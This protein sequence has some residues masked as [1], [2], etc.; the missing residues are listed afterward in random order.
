M[1]EFKSTDSIRKLK[2]KIRKVYGRRLEVKINDK[3]GDAINVK[4]DRD[5]KTIIESFSPPYRYFSFFSSSDN[6]KK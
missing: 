2:S 4:T 1:I 5:L 3:D 6:N